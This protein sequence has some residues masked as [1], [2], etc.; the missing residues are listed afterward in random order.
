[1]GKNV[2]MKIFALLCST[3]M[4]QAFVTPQKPVAVTT[5]SLEASP[6]SIIAATAGAVPAIISSSAALATEGTNEWFGVDDPRVLAALF[7][8]H[9]F[10]LSLYLSQYK[11]DDEED[12]FF[13]AI[14]YGAVDRGEQR[15]FM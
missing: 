14:D 3:Y 1:M 2:M 5:T 13:G 7:T 10:I 8:G 11:P 9:F 4:V 15:P 6:R 12:D